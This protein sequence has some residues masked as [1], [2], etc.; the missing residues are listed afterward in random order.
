MHLSC[1]LTPSDRI[2]RE[3]TQPRNHSTASACISL[4]PPQVLNHLFSNEG[5]G[6]VSVDIQGFDLTA[7]N[8]QRGRDHGLAGYV[9]YLHTC[10]QLPNS[11]FRSRPKPTSFQVVFI[12]YIFHIILIM[13]L[14]DICSSLA[15]GAC[16]C[17][18]MILIK[19]IDRPS[20][21]LVCFLETPPTGGLKHL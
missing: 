10:N 18:V 2:G 17:D 5:D 3:F 8:V 14:K 11:K 21:D 7:L 6:G 16:K 4:F 20:S 19:K 15:K 13:S 12:S 1:L 9:E